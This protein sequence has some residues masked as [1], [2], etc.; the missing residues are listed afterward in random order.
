MEARYPTSKLNSPQR[1]A[2][3]SRR[4]SA[5]IESRN[6]SPETH[7]SDRTAQDGLRRLTY[8]VADVRNFV[9]VKVAH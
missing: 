5:T 1:I 2:L 7:G 6:D 3:G 8:S 9:F 4:P